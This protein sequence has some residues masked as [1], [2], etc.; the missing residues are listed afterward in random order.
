MRTLNPRFDFMVVAIQESKDMKAVKIEEL[1][2]S[3]EP[4]NL[5]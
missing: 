3:L 2:S 4:V 1:H 5:W